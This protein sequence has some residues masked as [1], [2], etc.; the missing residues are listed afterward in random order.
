MNPE[1]V[2]SLETKNI[3]FSNHSQL[4]AR[5]RSWRLAKDLP[6]S[7]YYAFKGISYGFLSQRNFRIQL[8]FGFFALILGAW[9]QIS[10][11]KL[12][13]IVFTIALVLILEL[14]NTSI[15]AVVDLAIGPRFHPLARIAKDCAAGSVLISAFGSFVVALLLLLPP[16]LIHLGI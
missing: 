6:T 9:L 5:R 8:G 10:L 2:K 3:E 1:R 11:D 14:I 13:I 12:A 4:S 15:E 16:L 7:F